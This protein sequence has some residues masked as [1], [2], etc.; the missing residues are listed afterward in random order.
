M[1]LNREQLENLYK[2]NYSSLIKMCGSEDAIHENFL[3]VIE[4]FEGNGGIIDER[5]IKCHLPAD[6]QKYKPDQRLSL[7]EELTYL[8]D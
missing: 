6:I 5:Y 1:K 2:T 4:K 8:V 3:W 7:S